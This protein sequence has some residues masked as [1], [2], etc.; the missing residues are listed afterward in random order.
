MY[1]WVLCY[2]RMLVI[3]AADVVSWSPIGDHY[4]LAV[5]KTVMVHSLE[6]SKRIH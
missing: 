5:G 3:A 6:V 4:V 1:I 2:I